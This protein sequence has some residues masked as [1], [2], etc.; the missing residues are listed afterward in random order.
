MEDDKELLRRR[1]NLAHSAFSMLERNGLLSYDRKSGAVNSTFLGKIASFYY[2]KHASMAIYNTNL[3][4]NC[5]L[6]ELLR[7][8][9]MSIEFKYLVVREE[10]KS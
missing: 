10:E 7:V 1:V 2:I 9:A 6:I 4:S 8:F 5:G 3:K